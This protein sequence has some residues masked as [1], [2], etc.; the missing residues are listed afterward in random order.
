MIA[1]LRH[2]WSAYHQ[3]PRGTPYERRAKAFLLAFGIAYLGSCDYA[4]Q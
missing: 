2:F 1:S 3:A 4:A